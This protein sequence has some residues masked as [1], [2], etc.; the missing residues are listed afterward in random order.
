MN[1]FCFNN[2]KQRTYSKP[3]NILNE[4]DDLNEKI[5]HLTIIKNYEENQIKN[6]KSNTCLQQN[7]YS[8][9]LKKTEFSFN[10]ND[11]FLSKDSTTNES[12]VALEKYLPPREK[13][14]FLD[15]NAKNQEK[16]K[17]HPD[18]SKFTDEKTKKEENLYISKFSKGKE[19]K[20]RSKSFIEKPKS[21]SNSNIFCGWLDYSICERTNL[22]AKVKEEK[23]SQRKCELLI[24]NERECTFEPKIKRGE[25]LCGRFSSY[26]VETLKKI[27]KEFGNMEGNAYLRRRM[28]KNKLEEFSKPLVFNK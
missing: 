17:P 8:S 23:L 6:L 14:K 26:N 25:G 16:K 7:H 19:V 20:P 15:Y 3:N 12:D 24:E 1:D 13:Y 28:L 11:S 21:K 9:N 10:K 4:I 2:D 5:K 22:W 27:Q 18:T